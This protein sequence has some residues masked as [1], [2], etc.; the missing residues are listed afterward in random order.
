MVKLF[1]RWIAV[2]LVSF[3]AASAIALPSNPQKNVDYQM[4]KVPQP[5]HSG[6]KVE[7]IE[8]FGYFCP[9]CY[10]FDTALTN[11]ARKHKKNVVFK[12]VAVKFSESMT[13]HQKM[14]Y[15]LSAMDELTNELH[16][17]I[18]DAVQVQRLPL[19]TDE[20]IFDFVEKNG[21]DRK[22]F[23]EMYNSFYVQM[24]GSKA[25][26]M[27]TAYEIEG[28]P[29]IAIDGKYLTSPAIVSSGNDMDLSEEEMHTQTL[30]VMDVL[31]NKVL[32]EKSSARKSNTSQKK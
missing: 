9:H 11:W 24:L 30:K 19:R 15:T 8:F 27:Q 10:A 16:H 6:D 20:Q 7:V 18:F 17:K 29:M 13:L 12:R 1:S 5:T 22:K 3:M 23:T 31:V 32:K 2:M 21:V 14:F 4:L 25:V 26:E 28:V